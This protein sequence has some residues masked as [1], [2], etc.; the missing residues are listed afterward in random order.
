MKAKIPNVRNIAK[1][2]VS[3]LELLSGALG[4]FLDVDGI[5]NDVQT[6]RSKICAFVTHAYEEAHRVRS[7]HGC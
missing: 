7:V 3:E 6:N 2:I 4:G 5:Q 1:G